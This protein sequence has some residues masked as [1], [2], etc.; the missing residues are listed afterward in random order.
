MEVW[1]D[2]ADNG[3]GR[4]AGFQIDGGGDWGWLAVSI[5]YSRISSRTDRRLPGYMSALRLWGLQD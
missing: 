1:S 5:L 4:V 2:E 3:D